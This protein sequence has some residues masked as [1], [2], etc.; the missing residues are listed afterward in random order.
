MIGVL[1]R[2]LSLC[3]AYPI[4]LVLYFVTSAN[5]LSSISLISKFGF[6]KVFLQLA[7]SNWIKYMRLT[8]SMSVSLFLFSLSR[9]SVLDLV[10]P[11]SFLL[12]HDYLLG[13]FSCLSSFSINSST[14]FSICIGHM[15]FH[16][17][18]LYYCQVPT[19]LG[20]SWISS[21]LSAKQMIMPTFLTF[22]SMYD[23]ALHGL[24]F[25]SSLV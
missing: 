2:V 14:H 23:V 3:W 20:L 13:S 24:W 17:G 21:F 5:L 19:M 16:C 11:I 22:F 9:V 25:C 18:H 15:S 6:Q 7:R 1:L 4:S 12:Y 10:Y 8:L